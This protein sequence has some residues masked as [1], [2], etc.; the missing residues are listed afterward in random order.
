M[1]P[2]FFFDNSYIQIVFVKSE[3]DISELVETMRQIF[4]SMRAW[5]ENYK[6]I[7]E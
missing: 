6:N 4:D 7:R 1:S 3:S 5:G 2:F